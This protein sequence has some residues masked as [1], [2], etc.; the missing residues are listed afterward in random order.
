MP[1]L[2]YGERRRRR[3]LRGVWRAHRARSTT[4]TRP[5]LDGPLPLDRRGGPRER[6][7]A[8]WE[9]LV[10][11]PID[12]E[13][14]PPAEGSSVARRAPPRRA[15]APSPA[16]H[17]LPLRLR[18]QTST[19][20]PSWR[21]SRCIGSGPRPG[22]ARRRGSSTGRSSGRSSPSC[23]CRSSGRPDPASPR[24]DVVVLAS[25]VVALVA[26]A[27]QWLGVTLIGATPGMRLLG[28]QVVGPDGRRPLSGAKRG[29]RPPG[30]LLG[31]RPAGWGFSWRCSLE[32]DEARTT[33]PPAPGWCWS[34]TGGKGGMSDPLLARLVADGALSRA[35]TRSGRW[36]ART[37]TGGSMDTVLLELRLVPA[38]APHRDAGPGHRPAGAAR[39]G[40][41]GA[42]SHGHGASS[43]PRSPSGTASPRSPSTAASSRW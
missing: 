13:M 2:P 31:G 34:A 26:F 8:T 16:R 6:S 41:R 23:S 11:V 5:S 17:A 7:S 22:S 1:P 32:V 24:R 33:S 35:R 4:S 27:Y 29:P 36:R 10:P 18:R 20:T 12:W 15:I 42:R 40:L 38:L 21:P 19:S 9:S 37:R 3:P 43:P 30:A 28:L 39:D 25:M 14:A